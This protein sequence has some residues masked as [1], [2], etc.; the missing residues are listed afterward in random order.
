MSRVQG[1]PSDN[2]DGQDK[3]H[4][5]LKGVVCRSVLSGATGVAERPKADGPG[6]GLSSLPEGQDVA[7]AVP[8]KQLAHTI[9]SVY[10]PLDDIGFP[11]TQLC[12]EFVDVGHVDVSIERLVHH[13]SVRPGNG[14]FRW[15]R[16]TEHDAD[17]IAPDDREARWLAE[18][19][20]EREAW[21]RRGIPIAHCPASNLKIE[22]R[23]IPLAR[24]VG[25][26]PIGLGTDWTVT[27]NSM[28]LLAEARLAALVGKMQADRKSV[29]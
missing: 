12:C 15:P 21:V 18:E 29:V 4:H 20:V 6:D 27:N 16:L 8:H 13:T 17:V 14:R 3:T 19:F 11:G 26:V 2:K 22:A 5:L 23:T 7:V 10:R 25:R 1:G 24:L 9:D 28:D